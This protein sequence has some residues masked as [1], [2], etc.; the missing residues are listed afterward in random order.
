MRKIIAAALMFAALG[1]HTIVQGDNIEDEVKITVTADQKTTFDMF[2]SSH[3]V[4][5]GLT[6]PYE[7]KFSRTDSH[8]IFKSQKSK[9]NLKIKVEVNNQTALTAEWPITVVLITNSSFTTFGME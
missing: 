8:F 6:T 1:T 4:V 9:T 2:Q 5:K 3:G 7:M